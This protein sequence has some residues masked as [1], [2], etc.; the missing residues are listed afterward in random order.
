MTTPDYPDWTQPV[1]LVD[2]A[3]NLSPPGNQLVPNGA[4]LA[5]DTSALATLDFVI[6]PPDAASLQRYDLLVQ[7]EQGGDVFGTD[8]VSMYGINTYTLP[9]EF[10]W[11]L[12]CR[13]QAC[14]VYAVG[15]DPTPINVLIE[16]STRQ[17]QAPRILRA[18]SEGRNA[19]M[20]SGLQNVAAGASTPNY[21]APPVS[22]Q[23]VACVTFGS[24]KMFAQGN[25]L[26]Y[27]AGGLS[28]V[29]LCAIN[30]APTGQTA[31]PLPVVL[32]AA[33]MS[34]VWNIHNSDTVAHTAQ[35]VVYDGSP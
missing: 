19:I 13:S 4:S 18:G 29:F 24:T 25:A 23:L 35:I 12:P 16:S 31:T 32:P 11:Q 15:S 14:T 10:G 22:Q 17:L 3:T 6:I 27:G 2:Q 5:L 8:S 20:D 30:A 7:W 1:A 28:D 33:S 34:T 21:Y 9:S 26:C